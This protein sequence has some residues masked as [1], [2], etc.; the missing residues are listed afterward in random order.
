[1]MEQLDLRR[2]TPEEFAGKSV[3]IGGRHYAIGPK[4]DGDEGHAHFIVNELSGLC[5]HVMQVGKQYLSN[6]SGALAASRERARE[7]AD[8]RSNMLRNGEQITLPLVSVIEG[9]G[10]SFELHET[11]WGAFGHTEDS[12]GRESIDLAVSQSEAGDQRSAVGVLSALLESHPN[13]SVAL[14]LLAGV[15][16]D[17]GDQASA[18]QIFARSIEIEPNYAKIRGQQVVAAMRAT[19]R[20]QALELFQELKAR[21]PLLNDYDGVGISAYLICGEP[22]QA[23]TLLQKNSLPKPDAEQLLTQITYALE[24]KQ[25]LSALGEAVEKRL[26][27]ETDLLECLEALYKAYPPDPLIQANLGSALYRAGHYQRAVEL[28]VAGGGGIADG[29]TIY[30]GVNLAFALMKMSAWEAAMGM[31]SDVMNDVLSKAAHGVAVTPSEVPGLGEWF[32]DK[33]IL[34]TRRHSNYRLLTAA[35]G[36]CPD[37]NLITPL[38]RQLAELYRQAEPAVAPAPAAPAAPA[39]AV[40]AAPPAA[41]ANAAPS[42]TNIPVTP[43]PPATAPAAMEPETTSSRNESSMAGTHVAHTASVL[44]NG[45]VLVAGGGGSPAD[46]LYDPSSNTWS[47][48]GSLATS[49][50]YHTATVLPD[51]RVLVAGG[52][53][54]GTEL[55]SAELYD[56]SSNVWSNAGSLEIPR[57]RHTATLLPAGKT[58]IAGGRGRGRIASGAELY[59]PSANAWSSAGKLAK[60]RYEHSATLLLSGKVLVAG[61][62][63]GSPYLA[64]AELYDPSSNTWS[65]GGSLATAR[66]GHTA[67]LLA[68]GKVLV[69][70][71]QNGRPR[72]VANAELYDPSSNTWSSA[73]NLAMPRDLHTATLLPNGMV[74]IAGGHGV[75]GC[76]CSAEVYD[77]SNNTW[78][79][80]ADLAAPREDHTATLLPSG[81]VLISGGKGSAGLLSSAELYDPST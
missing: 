71:G 48:T 72:F 19:R 15:V 60:G 1:M 11:T 43:A 20:R 24:V 36:E 16:C 80:T 31:L 21:Y 7:T 22:Q 51:G 13:H 26:I 17:M 50:A 74:L 59:D 56:A 18:Q 58:L 78:T 45:K 79:S 12:P 62:W 28:L 49:R 39:A 75:R 55:S 63:G 41:T 23:L 2:H 64:T 69:V 32:A 8:L 37:Q 47:P 25:Q 57:E 70:G 42:T 46:E 33:G 34:K 4:F 61:G 10:G 3:T 40:P 35:M 6:P 67:T 27:D 73:G 44:P 81:K 14:G 68:S 77:P 54:A 66:E 5:L 76:L 52:T 29:L 53:G 30:C 9:N 65:D 38:I